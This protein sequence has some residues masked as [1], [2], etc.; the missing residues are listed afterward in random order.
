MNNNKIVAIL[1]SGHLRNMSEHLSNFELN[2]LNPLKEGGYE[3][4]IY[5]HTW[6]TNMTND[7]IMNNDKYYQKYSTKQIIKNIKSKTKIK[8][9]KI[10]NQDKISKESQ[11]D[12][13]INGITGGRTI[14]GQSDKYY[15]NNLTNKLLFQFY[16]HY[17]SLRLVPDLSKYSHV[18]KTRPDAYYFRPF[19]I[20]ILENELTFPDTHTHGGTN[21]NQIFFVGESNIMANILQYFDVISRDASIIENYNAKNDNH[22]AN[23]NKIFRFYIID[24]LGLNPIFNSFNPGL[25]RSAD[26][27][28]KIQK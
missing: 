22:D 24:F 23:V 20:S 3:Y 19:D 9:I 11:F 6:D 18:I 8:K 14:H 4:H 27:I 21:I 15:C 1:L 2:L 7:K 25:Y 17:A 5:I 26:L 12:K 16:G 10:E 13:I 28:V